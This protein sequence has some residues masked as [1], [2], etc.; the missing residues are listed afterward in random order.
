MELIYWWLIPLG[1]LAVGTALWGVRRGR[2]QEPERAVA[3]TAR[4]TGL[5]E[6]RAALQRHRRLM[7][8]CVVTAAVLLL[9]S[10]AAAARPVSTAV[11]TPEQHSRDI[12]LCLDTSASMASADAAITAVFEELVAGF[13]GERIGL[14]MFDSSTAHVFPL[15]DD[16]ELVQDQ[17]ARARQAFD[18]N[19]DDPSFFAGTGVGAGSSLVG[20]GLAACSQGFPGPD[21][22]TRS[23]SV[24]FATDN[25]VAGSP[26]F[27]LAQAAQLAGE[28]GARVYAL[29][30]ADFD[31]GDTAGQP[32]AELRGA[33]EST[34]GAYYPLD[35]AG[36]V[37]GIVAAVQQTE[38]A[39]IQ[40]APVRVA[41][42]AAAI[43]LGVAL[44]AVLALVLLL[45]RVER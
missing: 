39:K 36:A 21:D 17:L 20:D 31:F 27:T 44:V 43:P 9:A 16:Y 14:M 13:D 6:Y 2:S 37:A 8:W 4:L 19:L 30:P 5:P 32:G 29:N 42:D 26:I 1:V 7:T 3:H 23:R 34:G 15:T 25:F 41:S 22:G 33:A 11:I 10:L 18:G 35:S 45:W 12:M 28:K 24:V 38:A 40:G